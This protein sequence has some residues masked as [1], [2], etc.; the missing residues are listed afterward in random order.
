MELKHGDDYQN[1]FDSKDYIERFYSNPNDCIDV[2]KFGFETRHD[3]FG[4]GIVKGKR[5]ID[6]GCGPI[7]EGLIPAAKWFKELY[8]ADFTERNR[9]ELK[10]W[11]A[12]DSEAHDWQPFFRYY[13]SKDGREQSWEND[14][15]DFRS[16][17]KQVLGC[18]YHKTN[19][20]YPEHRDVFD[21]VTSSFALE[22]GCK[23]IEEF[24]RAMENTAS[25]IKPGGYFIILTALN[26]LYYRAGEV[27]R[28]LPV[29]SDEVK[30]ALDCARID[31]L[32]CYEDTSKILNADE[33]HFDGA[34]MV[35]GKKRT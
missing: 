6:I 33:V 14:E 17:V 30:Q 29:T 24:R 18:D 5:I 21:A 22:C 7:I 1:F 2:I 34:L 10:K 28:N 13:A 16:K 11:L 32:E 23:D 12:M 25:L 19:P 3:I 35:L 20:L 15:V 27:F 31:I 8:L 9:N 26:N 4:K